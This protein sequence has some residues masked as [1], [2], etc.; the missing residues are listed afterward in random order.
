MPI[1]DILGLKPGPTLLVTAGLDGDEYPPI[2][3][4]FEAAQRYKDGDFAGRL[5]ILPIVNIAGFDAGTSKNPIDG[6]YPKYCIPGRLFGTSSDRLMR[7]VVK[8]YAQHSAL[9]LDLHSAAQGETVIPCLWNNISGVAS[10]DAL[11]EAFTRVS[12]VI[13]AV[14]EQG[15]RATCTLAKH[16]CTYVIAESEEEE[17]H[18]AYIEHALQVLGMIPDNSP[19]QP[20][21]IFTKTRDMKTFEETPNEGELVLW[22]KTTNLPGHKGRFGEIAYEEI[23]E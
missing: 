6:K 19:T 20:P 2:A 23:T 22:Q 4:A 11:G 14:R 17:Q 7:S 21:R 18:A 9:W 13:A 5:I 3:A 1:A 10:V 16:G 12:G 8:T 15:G